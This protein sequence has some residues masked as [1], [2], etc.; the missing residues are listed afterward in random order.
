MVRNAVC[1]FPW[2]PISLA[3]QTMLENSFSYLPIMVKEKGCDVWKLISDHSIAVFLRSAN[4]GKKR[5]ERLAMTLEAA[6]N[7]KDITLDEPERRDSTF[8]VE[9]ALKSSSKL[10][11]LVVRVWNGISITTCRAIRTTQA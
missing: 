9:D 10:P 6:I 1:A 3:R 2:Q 4:A 11:I 5:A 8:S 7:S